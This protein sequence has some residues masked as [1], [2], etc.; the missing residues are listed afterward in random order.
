VL[1]E[2][3]QR[4]THAGGKQA[5][6]TRQ[7]ASRK[8]MQIGVPRCRKRN[9]ELIG[10]RRAQDAA[11]AGTGD[12]DQVG[13]KAFKRRADASEVPRKQKIKCQIR[14]QL[15]YGPAVLQFK[16]L[17]RTFGPGTCF[18]PACTDKNG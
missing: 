5:Q 8:F 18:G 4:A 1:G 17:E 16:R 9:S 3:T 2:A 14:I 6:Q 15:Q 7:T 12:V 13:P 11:M 10:Q